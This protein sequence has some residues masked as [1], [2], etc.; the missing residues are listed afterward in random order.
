MINYAIVVGI[1]DIYLEKNEKEY[2]MR[3]TEN[4][5]SRVTGVLNLDKSKYLREVVLSKELIQ[6]VWPTF[7]FLEQDSS[8]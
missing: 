7:L 3:L 1:K 8:S 6:L 4:R 2:L 5:V